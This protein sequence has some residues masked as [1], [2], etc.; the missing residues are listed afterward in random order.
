MGIFFLFEIY[1]RI[2]TVIGNSFDSDVR[3]RKL[4]FF[5][6]Y[7]FFF[8]WLFFDRLHRIFED[9]L[10]GFDDENFTYLLE[11][12]HVCLCISVCKQADC[13]NKWT[14]N[15]SFIRCSRREGE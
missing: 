1:P 15:C 4:H 10:N 7:F 6:F 5:P 8:V 9:L 11:R 3:V 2:I 13:L 14:K 12:R